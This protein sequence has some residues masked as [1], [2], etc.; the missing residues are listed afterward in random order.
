M[1]K[2]SICGLR[3]YTAQMVFKDGAAL[4]AASSGGQIEVVQLLLE[5]GADV[6]VQGRIDI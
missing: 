3:G 5:K 6:N 1:P 4:R 2:V